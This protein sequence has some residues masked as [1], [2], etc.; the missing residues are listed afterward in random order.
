MKKT[1]FFALI[2]FAVAFFLPAVVSA[3]IISFGVTVDSSSLAGTA[4]NLEFQFAPGLPTPL[5]ATATIHDFAGATLT[6]APVTSGSVSGSL[7]SSVIINNSSAGDYYQPVAYGSSLSF[8]L[9]INETLNPASGGNIFAFSMFGNAVP[10]NPVLT[11][12][13]TDGFAFTLAL[14]GSGGSTLT[15]YSAQTV[16]KV[17]VPEPASALLLLVGVALIFSLIHR[18]HQTFSTGAPWRHRSRRSYQISHL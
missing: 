9:S 14:P 18:A 4:G 3:D 1:S 17:I 2:W 6:G 5:P 8:T 11:T 15:N 13:L 16:V 12:N 7:L 10:P